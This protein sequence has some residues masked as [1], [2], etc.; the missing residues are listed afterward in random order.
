MSDENRT[1]VL[2]FVERSLTVLADRIEA[3]D[4]ETTFAISLFLAGAAD[5]FAVISSLN[6]I[7]RF[8]LIRETVGALD[9]RS[10]TVDAFTQKFTDY[11]KDPKY[12]PLIHAG[13]RVMEHHL[14]EEPDCFADLPNL[15]S[16]WLLNH[17]GT[18]NDVPQTT[19]MITDLIDL[20]SSTDAVRTHNA[21]VRTALAK[22]HG[23]ETEHTGDGIIASFINALAALG[24][25]IRIQQAISAHNSE[26]PDHSLA[27]R[28]GIY[29]GDAQIDNQLLTS[30]TVKMAASI[31]VQAEDGDIL[32][33][34]SVQ[35]QCQNQGFELHD[36]ANGLYKVLF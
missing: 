27:L 18:G 6:N 34:G 17:D 1:S 30:P 8:I 29:T 15:I 19:I 25:A 20:H 9:T 7:Q 31:C 21:I 12:S 26:N 36:A 28:I 16:G 3:L 5:R 13:K 14:A 11:S 33:S 32:V 2:R 10:D 35:E 24:A 23:E 22:T 4:P